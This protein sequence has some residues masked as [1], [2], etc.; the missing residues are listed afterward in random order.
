MIRIKKPLD[1]NPNPKQRKNAAKAAGEMV[2]LVCETLHPRGSPNEIAVLADESLKELKT[3][4]A[5]TENPLSDTL[6][7]IVNQYQ[8]CDRKVIKRALLAEIVKQLKFGKVKMFVDSLLSL[9]E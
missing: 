5:D 1:K 8:N 7:S 4:I 6:K 2:E 3:I 9:Y